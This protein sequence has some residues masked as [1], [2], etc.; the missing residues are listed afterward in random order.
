MCLTQHFTAC[1]EVINIIIHI[2]CRYYV[3]FGD[4]I[5]YLGLRFMCRQYI[6]LWCVNSSS[7]ICQKNIDLYCAF[8]VCS[9]SPYWHP[10]LTVSAWSAVYYSIVCCAWCA[11]LMFTSLADLPLL[12]FLQKYYG[13]DAKWGDIEQWM[14]G[15]YK[16]SLCVMFNKP[17]ELCS[18]RS[19]R[20]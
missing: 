18:V 19:S 12:S 17:C 13:L 7:S 5:A 15:F 6:L 9:F 4:D 2:I 3:L 16:Q 14:V 10:D 1:F 8:F 11:F 20:C